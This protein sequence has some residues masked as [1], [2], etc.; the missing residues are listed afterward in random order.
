M[1]E[2]LPTPSLLLDKERLT[3]NI[4]RMQKVCTE[5]GVALW[6]HIKTHKCIEIARM[7]LE[8]GAAG[9][10]CAKIGEAEAMLGSGVRRIFIAH[11]LVDPLQGKRLRT[12]SESLDELV[13]AVTSSGQAEKLESLLAAADLKLPVMM[14]I[15][16]GLGREGVRGLEQARALADF[17]RKQPNLKL[18]GIYTHEGQ[19]YAL[20]PA[21]RS[22]GIQ[23]VYNTLRETRDAIDP[24]L[25]LW[26]GCS[27]SAAEM[28]AL[29][30]VDVVRPGAYVFGD[31]ALAWKSRV[32][33]PEEVAVT[34]LATVVDRPSAELALL[35][36]GSKTFSGDK[37]A[38]GLS[39]RIDDGR[40]IVVSRVNEE[41]GYATGADVDSLKIGEK[42]RFVPAHICPVINLAD[43]MT[44]LENGQV[45]GSWTVDARGKVQ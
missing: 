38:E 34:V 7:Q 40:E 37:T 3:A 5:N 13:V 10:T 32:M 18:K 41:H 21:Q 19:T 31:M 14:A 9:V 12:L 45:T 42:V 20:D 6:P 25:Q 43:S 35:D 22:A 2:T 39:G 23:Q 24:A 4:E 8:A 28:A 17:V 11:S 16:T 26:P 36:A 29:P 15:D 33:R 1:F 44:V 27:V 30:G